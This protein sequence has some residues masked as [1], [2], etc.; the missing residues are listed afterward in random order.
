MGPA[1][2]NVQAVATE[3][4]ITFSYSTDEPGT[5]VVLRL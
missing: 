1:I 2:S 4:S 3:S 5:T